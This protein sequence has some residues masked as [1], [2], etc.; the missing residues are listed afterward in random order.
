M[1]LQSLCTLALFHMSVHVSA[2]QSIC[3]SNLEL[4]CNHY[5]HSC[6][7]PY[8]MCLTYVFKA[9]S[10]L[11]SIKIH[12]HANQRHAMSA[13]AATKIYHGVRCFSCHECK[14][15]E[16]RKAWSGTRK[17]GL[18]ITNHEYGLDTYSSSDERSNALKLFG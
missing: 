1:L 16:P 2:N 4:W 8:C 3:N 14:P 7:C 18:V 17:A 9:I 5:P 12:I 6:N 15:Q 10:S 13:H 11:S